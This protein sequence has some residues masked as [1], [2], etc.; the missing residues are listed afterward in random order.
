MSQYVALPDILPNKASRSVPLDF[1]QPARASFQAV[2]RAVELDPPEVNG[3]R[4]QTDMI[5]PTC[6]GEAFN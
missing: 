1:I 3:V 4:F 2:L 5:L 6:I